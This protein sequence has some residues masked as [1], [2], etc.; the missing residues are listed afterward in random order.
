MYKNATFR[1]LIATVLTAV[2]GLAQDAAAPATSKTLS[3]DWRRVGTT[4]I[5]LSLAGLASGP[6]DR[7]WYA[8]PGSLLIHTG[9]GRVFESNDFETWH[10]SNAAVPPEVPPRIPPATLPDFDAH[11][12]AGA[13]TLYAV[14]K[15]AY[16]SDSNGAAWD[17]LTS[18]RGVSIVGELADL[19]VSPANDDEVVIGGSAGVFR[20]MDGGK[21]WSGLNQTLPNLPTVRLLT[22]PSGDHGVRIALSDSGVVAWDP[23][24]K[25]AWTPSD[26]TDYARELQMRRFYGG[27]RGI[28]VTAVSVSGEYIYT[29]MPD[30]K[31]AVSADRGANWNTFQAPSGGTVES[32]WIDP[33]D[34]RIALAVFGARVVDNGSGVPAVHVARTQ[35]G[36]LFWDDLTSNLPDVAAHGV[37]AD[38]AT[39]AIYVATSSGVFMSYT[40]L[41]AVGQAPRW[42]PI[43]GLSEAAVTDVKLDEQGHQ[44]WAATEGYGVYSMLAPHRLLDPRVVSTANQVAQAT[45]P[46]ALVSVLGARVDAAHAGDLAVPVL[47]ATDN[48]SQLQVPFEARGTSVAL[49]ITNGSGSRTLPNIPLATA[50]PA[51][52]VDRDGTPVLLDAESGVMLDAMNPAHSRGRIQILATGLGRV[53]PDW[54]TGIPA[55]QENPPQVV[56][57][58]QAFID[59]QPVEVSRAVL[60]P[61]IGFYVIEIEVPK[62][63][64]YGPAELYLTVDGQT[65]NRVRVY[66]QP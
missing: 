37:T 31:L 23:G 60:A 21:T 19:A 61:Y 40:D 28:P 55:P 14:A 62:I 13:Q 24:Q 65:S 38:A 42:R 32:F 64:N 5:D 11:V 27:Q 8:N 22:L 44:L 50:A 18:F 17:N 45:A 48:E 15:F 57:P 6:V 58:V 66:I 46:G 34:P 41:A 2:S 39:G 10:P 54:P 1:I 26:N 59:R 49:A 56:A 4:A 33:K 53:T 63:V 7:V 36:G 12:R 3:S 35:N 29:G 25:I 20:S 43:P 30:A 47:A 52:F 16:R 51:I 9:S